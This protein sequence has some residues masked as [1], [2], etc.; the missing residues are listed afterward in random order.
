MELD[1]LHT[2]AREFADRW[3]QAHAGLKSGE[4]DPEESKA[5]R[6][7]ILKEADDLG[8]LEDVV[9]LVCNDWVFNN[10]EE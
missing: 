7:A 9:E 8:L 10:E 4:V 2:D 3:M 1:R 5:E 6:K